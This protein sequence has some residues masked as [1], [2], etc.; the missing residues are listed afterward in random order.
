MAWVKLI[1]DRSVGL[2]ISFITD[3][4]PEPVMHLPSRDIEHQ[5]MFDGKAPSKFK[6][7][8]ILPRTDR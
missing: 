8:E 5:L 1:A 4:S 3:F 6:S 2:C 7:S